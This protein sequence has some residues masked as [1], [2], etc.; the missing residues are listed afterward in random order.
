MPI[1]FTNQDNE[2]PI[3]ET[4]EES[5]GS[6]EEEDAGDEESQVSASDYEGDLSDI[7]IRMMFGVE[8]CGAIFNLA[9]DKGAF[10][11]VCGCRLEGC[12][13]GHQTSRLTNRAKPGSYETVRSRK[14][15]DG[16]LETW[17]PVEEY[18]AEARARKVKQANDIKEAA[19]IL[20][21]A[22]TPESNKSSSPS[23]S[24]ED[25]YSYASRKRIW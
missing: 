4:A 21:K 1:S 2:P 15:V 16:K 17:I 8:E 9:S 6:N 3:V 19:I 24:E 10:F 25:A 20:T 23:R 13:R 22:R 7:P 12:K 11:R 14:Y 5:F 18:E